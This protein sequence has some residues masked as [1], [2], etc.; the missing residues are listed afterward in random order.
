MKTMQ[1]TKISTQF[2]PNNQEIVH[3]IYAIIDHIKFVPTGDNSQFWRFSVE[4]N[5]LKIYYLKEVAR[6]SIDHYQIA[7][8][9]SLGCLIESIE[10]CARQFGLNT[11]IDLKIDNLESGTIAIVCF[12]PTHT[13]ATDELFPFIQLRHTNRYPLGTTAIRPHL[14]QAESKFAKSLNLE[15]SIIK[16][17]NNKFFDYLVKCECFVWKHKNCFL[18]TVKWIRFNDQQTLTYKDGMSLKNVKLKTLDGF[19]IRIFQKYP[20]L[21]KILWHLGL[22][23]KVKSDAKKSLK[24]A[25]NLIGFFAKDTE[26]QTVINIG[27]LAYRTWLRLN[28]LNYGVQPLSAASMV[29]FGLLKKLPPPNYQ[30]SYLDLFMS[31]FSFVHHEFELSDK[32]FLVWM[33]K[34]GPSKELAK[35][36]KSLRKDSQ[37]LILKS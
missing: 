37:D 21:L 20:I 6:H 24:M 28:S 12:E 34:V 8:L 30:K 33:F 26:N 23:I 5:L 10:I 3:K 29:A 19:F 31:S 4:Q 14:L 17:R 11:T 2:D 18:D 32:N 25:S 36:Y 35:E 9:I 7:S 13:F 27:R 1:N 15:L 16:I 22:S